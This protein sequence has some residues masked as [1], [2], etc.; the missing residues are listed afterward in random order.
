MSRF[1]KKRGFSLSETMIVIGIVGFIIALAV[2]MFNMSSFKNETLAAKQA[3]MESAI[4]TATMSIVSNGKI[5]AEQACNA[6][7]MRD[8]YA[9]K[10]NGEAIDNVTVN[11]N[12]VKAISIKDYGIV[13]FESAANCTTTWYATGSSPSDTGATAVSASG[14]NSTSSEGSPA[15]L[16]NTFAAQGPTGVA[17]LGSASNADKDDEDNMSSPSGMPK[18]LAIYTVMDAKPAKSGSSNIDITLPTYAT[19]SGVVKS[20]STYS[21]MY[22]GAG[23][24]TPWTTALNVN[25]SGSYLTYASSVTAEKSGATFDYSPYL[26][27]VTKCIGNYSYQYEGRDVAFYQ[28]LEGGTVADC[29]GNGI[30]DGKM[31]NIGMINS[32]CKLGRDQGQVSECTCPEGRT[33]FADVELVTGIQGVCLPSCEV[34]DNMYS[35]D[36]TNC[37]CKPGT[38]WNDVYKKCVGDECP[39]SYMKK[40]NGECVCKDA[41]ELG[42]DY[43][44]V[45]EVWVQD[46]S[47]DVACKQ[48]KDNWDKSTGTCVCPSPFTRTSDDECVCAEP[49]SMQNG[50]CEC[51]ESLVSLGSQEVFDPTAA[52]CKINCADYGMERKFNSSSG[53]YECTTP[54]CGTCLKTYVQGQGCVCDSAK[55]NKCLDLNEEV[56]DASNTATC[57]V[58]KYSNKEYNDQGVCACKE[59]SK[60]TFG[61]KEI[62]DINEPNCVYTCGGRAHANS[63]HTACEGA[64]LE[65]YDRTLNGGLGDLKCIPSPNDDKVLQCLAGSPY[66]ISKPTKTSCI[67]VC[68]ITEVADATH[69]ECVCDRARSVEYIISTKRTD[70]I[71]RPSSKYNSCIYQCQDGATANT[72]TKVIDGV[73]Y[74]PYTICEGACL[75][76]YNYD[77]NDGVGGLECI[78]NPD[79][80]KTTQCLSGYPNKISKPTATSCTEDCKAYESADAVHK[81]CICNKDRALAYIADQR[82]TT[83]QNKWI[84]NPDKTGQCVYECQDGATANTE[85][86]VVDGVTYEPYTIC[87]GACLQQYDYD[88]EKLECIPEPDNDKTTLCLA[89]YPNKISKPTAT[90]CTEDCKVYESADTVHKHCVCNR[91]RA[92]AYIAD[93]RKATG[94]NKWIYNPDKTGQCVYECKN[95]ATANSDYTECVGGCL[96]QYDYD[97]EVLNCVSNP[98]DD[99]VIS[100]LTG[101]NRV[102]NAKNDVCSIDCGNRKSPNSKYR[103][104]ECD[105]AKMD[106]NHLYSSD[107]MKFDASRENCEVSCDSSF[108]SRNPDD[109]TK[110]QC[111]VTKPASVVVQAKHF[112]NAL[113][114]ETKSEDYACQLRCPEDDEGIN[115]WMT[116]YAP[117]LFENNKKLIYDPEQPGCTDECEGNYVPSDDKRH[118]ICGITAKD[119]QAG[120]YFDYDA[121][122]CKICTPGHYC[123]GGTPDPIPC[124]CGTYGS[125]DRTLPDNVTELSTPACSGDCPAGYFCTEGSETPRENPCPAG[126]YCP[127]GHGDEYCG[128]RDCEKPSTSDEKSDVCDKC[129]PEADILAYNPNYFDGNYEYVDDLSK[130]CKKCISN[131][132]PNQAGTACECPDD[133]PYWDG[134]KCSACKDWTNTSTKLLY[135]ARQQNQNKA[136]CK[137]YDHMMGK[138]GTCFDYDRVPSDDM[139]AAANALSSADKNRKFNGV[140]AYMVSYDSATRKSTV[141][142]VFTARS[143]YNIFSG[144]NSSA[145]V[146]KS[147]QA[148]GTCSQLCGNNNECI[149]TCDY[150]KGKI[151]ANSMFESCKYVVR[152]EWYGDSYGDA[153]E[154]CNGGKFVVSSDENSCTYDVGGILRRVIS[155]IVLD[156][157][158]NGFE[159]TSVEEGVVFDL[160]NDGVPEKSAWTK[161]QKSFDNAFLVLD[162]NKNGQVDNGGEL[163][164]DQNGSENG[165]LELAKYDDN[166]DEVI[167][168]EDKVYNELMLWVDFNKNAKVDYEADGTT[169][170]LKSLEDAGVTEL[171]VNYEIQKDSKGNIL[172]DI[173]GNITGMLG[174][175]KMMVQ[176]AAGKLVEVVRKMMDVFFVTQ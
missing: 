129:L 93:Q 65:E 145:D 175:F 53:K 136:N 144:D 133:L 61:E 43:F 143:W 26:N 140:Y 84:Y 100:C 69:R 152:N 102:F 116:H 172:R 63:D 159:Y 24:F 108:T 30:V 170:E 52:D 103:V 173:Y 76:Q 151:T 156:L 42:D 36:G 59:K 119:C 21:Y 128:P 55:A 15:P 126:K 166:G 130:Q 169:Q 80:D 1:M 73:T 148:D 96:Q 48:L 68:D 123:P 168:K 161:K 113:R 134:T 88:K 82:R 81:N 57:K 12:E 98:E 138:K 155:P 50:A 20:G 78:P 149:E 67:E 91:D 162:K 120:T 18:A 158:G 27:D 79:S 150:L 8:K 137:L 19:A 112:Y 101:T 94:Q 104:C 17:K 31:I 171:S 90:S 106:K 118:C 62:Y 92:L 60:I 9:E 109:S 174:S 167:N 165:F 56:F 127:Q 41:D 64:C 16:A 71:Y 86:K 141:V 49:R 95:G 121:C 37:I 28:K 154:F 115:D 23:S 46:P 111:P 14:T 4:R 5:S 66:T 75:Q 7:Y 110:C 85:R 54:D 99:L 34:I 160:N 157:K 77:K 29:R 124:P 114:D 125:A 74:E 132:V 45:C 10:L 153:D 2:G 122:E 70:L 89:N 22:G 35:P 6:E 38:T 87:E 47:P 39:E 105:M 176:N 72:E 33:F 32:V 146:A 58:C 147:A 13:A 139:K 163:F 107:N 83:G 97:K 25:S 44:D 131:M 142:G 135:F 11:G 117:F 51:D 3:K 40:V 164:G